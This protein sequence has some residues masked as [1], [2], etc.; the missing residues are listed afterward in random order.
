HGHLGA[1]GEPVGAVLA[2]HDRGNAQLA[3][4]DRCMARPAPAIGD[5]RGSA[6]HHRFPVG[7]GH[8]GDEHVAILHAADLGDVHDHAHLALADLRADGAA[9]REHLAALADAIARERP[10][11]ALLALHGLGTRLEDVDPAVAA[12]LAPLDVHGAAVVL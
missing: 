9:R 12:I 5:D 11:L 8:V 3:R 6:L 7:I 4:D 10:A 2:S 1:L